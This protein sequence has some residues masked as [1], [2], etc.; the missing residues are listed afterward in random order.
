MGK[1][2][3]GALYTIL[4]FGLSY[5][6]FNGELFA[7]TVTLW[8]GIA[9]SELT[10]SDMHSKI[11]NRSGILGF[12]ACYVV[13][14]TCCISAMVICVI[15]ESKELVLL[16]ILACFTSDTCGFIVGKL[17]GKNNKVAALRNISPNKSYAGFFGAVFIATPI[18]YGLA[19]LLRLGS[20]GD[21]RLFIFASCSGIVA[22]TGDLIG[23]ATKRYLGIKDSG[24]D[25]VKKR[26]IGII[27]KPLIDG[28][29]GYYDRADS[30][31]MQ[32][33]FIW[34]IFVNQAPR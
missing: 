30:I 34:L 28:H 23:S 6:L 4:I 32:L 5:L 31:V 1:R 3:I 11:E 24:E 8:I 18:I 10:F 19:K 33:I 25:L 9:F 21:D 26:F 20:M 17:F 29:G 14:T 22:A 13:S 7:F 2:I 15:I 16:A 12:E 27:E